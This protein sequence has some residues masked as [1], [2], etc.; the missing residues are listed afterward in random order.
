MERLKIQDLGPGRA[1]SVRLDGRLYASRG[2]AVYESEDDGATWSHRTSLPV[3][4]KRQPGRFVRL[5]ARLLRFEVRALAA[6]ADGSL[7]AANRDWV[8]HA[9]PGERRVQACNVDEAGQ[10]LMPPFSITVGPD[11]RVLFGEYNPKTGHGTAVRLYVSEDGG[12]SFEIGRV[13]EGGSIMH[14]HNV[15]WDAA[16]EHYWVFTGDYDDEPGIG[17]LSADLA[18]FDWLVRGDQQYRLCEAFD[19][20][21]RLIYAT[22]T[23]LE[24]NAVMSIDKASGRTERLI[25]TGGSCL[26]ACRFGGV[27]AFSTTVESVSPDADQSISLWV[28]RDGDHWTSVLDA[29]K[30]RWHPNLFQFGSLILPRGPSEKETLF[31]SG[32]AVKRFDGRTF[33]GTLA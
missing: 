13:F 30:D 28:S 1:L 15:T 2:Y 20:G 22:D 6:L 19:F 18:H 8:F 29:E 5:A 27:Y 16:G 17:I 10:A 11:E 32:Q 24:P 9:K 7:V 26:Y 3:G 23:P 25:E 12:R 33:A 21:D 14:V 31:F 4:W